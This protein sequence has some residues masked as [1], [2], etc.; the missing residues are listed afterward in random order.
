[1]VGYNFGGHTG[2]R[3][4]VVPDWVVYLT[5]IGSF[6]AAIITSVIVRVRSARHGDGLLMEWV[7]GGL[8]GGLAMVSV[9]VAYFVVGHLVAML[10]H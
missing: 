8:S 6:V 4:M 3:T 1:M 5:G 2:Y 9:W 7:K 10:S